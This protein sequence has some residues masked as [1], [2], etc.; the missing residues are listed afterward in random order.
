MS[1]ADDHNADALDARA[2]R[3]QRWAGDLDT[4]SRR[5]GVSGDVRRLALELRDVA[6]LLQR[7]AGDLR[8]LEAFLRGAQL[9]A[10]RAGEDDAE[11]S[12]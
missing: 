12:A 9:L 6:A 4:W 3:L 11:R 8:L 1:H 2:R 10:P 5:V 7:F